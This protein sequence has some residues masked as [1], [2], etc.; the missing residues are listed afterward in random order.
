[1]RVKKGIA[2]ALVAMVFVLFLPAL[3]CGGMSGAGVLTLYGSEPST[4]DPA[5]C[6]DATS[7]GTLWK[8]LAAW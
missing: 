6:A 1:M 5:L 3:S 7:G 4:L 2:I 8:Y